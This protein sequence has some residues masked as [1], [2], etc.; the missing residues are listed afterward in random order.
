MLK[1]FPRLEVIS[2]HIKDKKVVESSQHGFVKEKCLTNVIATYNRTSASADKR[3]QLW[4][5]RLKG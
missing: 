4:R 2:K 5:A 3:Q 1:T